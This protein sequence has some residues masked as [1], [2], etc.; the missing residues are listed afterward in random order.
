MKS[1]HDLRLKSIAFPAMGTGILK[2][3]RD[4]VSTT[5]YEMVAEFEKQTPNTM[6]TTVTFVIYEKDLETFK[7]S[8]YNWL[9]K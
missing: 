3:P 8:G 6:V 2:Y 7:V 9:I 5:M 1:A 4:I